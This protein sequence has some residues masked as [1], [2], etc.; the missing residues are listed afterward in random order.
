MRPALASTRTAQEI[1]TRGTLAL[2]EQWS[3]LGNIRYDLDQ[4]QTIADAVGL[5]YQNDCLTLGL[6]YEETFIQDLDIKPD[7]R[8]LVSFALK[9]L[10]S[11]QFETDAFGL[12]GPSAT[13]SGPAATASTSQ[14]GPHCPCTS[15]SE[16]H[17]RTACWRRS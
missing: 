1:L 6:T 16:H 10:G 14:L 4:S 11:Y 2:T 5:Q 7:Q 13:T 12:L 9:Y 3:L 15:A 17:M 8:F